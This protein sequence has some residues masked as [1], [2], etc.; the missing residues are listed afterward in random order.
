MIMDL[1]KGVLKL[2]LTPILAL[3]SF[4]I[5]LEAV[6][7]VVSQVLG[8]ME[9]GLSIVN[10]FCPLNLVRPCILTVIAVYAVV[11]GYHLVM[12]VIKKIPFTGV[13]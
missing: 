5:D 12:W 1:L 7:G 3:F 11:N 9:D 4:A 8:Y 10:F 13:E 2:F 6:A